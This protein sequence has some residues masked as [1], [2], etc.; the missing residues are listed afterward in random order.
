MTQN[1]CNLLPTIRY[2]SHVA[3]KKT[4]R[5]K[6]NKRTKPRHQESMFFVLVGSK[7]TISFYIDHRRNLSLRGQ[8]NTTRSFVFSSCQKDF[9][10][11]SNFDS[12]RKQSQKLSFADILTT[13]LSIKLLEQH[14]TSKYQFIF[15]LLS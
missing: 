11:C 2:I 1:K 14:K 15:T 9:K 3:R 12:F 5:S 8:K 7:E 13:T 6:K 4:L 10:R